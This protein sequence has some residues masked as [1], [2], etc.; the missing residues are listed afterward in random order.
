MED[1]YEKVCK[2]EFD[3]IHNKLDKIDTSLITHITITVDLQNYSLF[4]II[5]PW[6]KTLRYDYYDETQTPPDPDTRRNFPLITS[7]GPDG[8]FETDDDIKNTE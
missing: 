4:R 6:G 2:G 7:A 5:D 8:R 3:Q 1:Q